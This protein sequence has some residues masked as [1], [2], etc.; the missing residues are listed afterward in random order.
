MYPEV[1]TGFNSVEMREWHVLGYF[2][3]RREPTE[4]PL[5]PPPP[6]LPPPP[7]GGMASPRPSPPPPEC[8]VAPGC[9]DDFAEGQSMAIVSGSRETVYASPRVSQLRSGSYSALPGK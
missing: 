3:G 8:L 6:R 4:L 1:Q 2:S 7:R 9:R 5:P